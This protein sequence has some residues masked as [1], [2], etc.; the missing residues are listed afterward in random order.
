MSPLKPL[1]TTTTFSHP[2]RQLSSQPPKQY[3]LMDTGRI[4]V[5]TPRSE[6]KSPKSAREGVASVSHRVRFSREGERVGGWKREKKVKIW[7][8]PLISSVFDRQTTQ[9]FYQN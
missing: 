9:K 8:P 4:I 1:S 2:L 7:D 6:F 3:T 5:Q